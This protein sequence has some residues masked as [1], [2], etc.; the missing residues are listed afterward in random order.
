M[1]KAMTTRGIIVQA[2]LGA[3]RL[4]SKIGMMLTDKL[5]MLDYLLSN[6]Q[7]IE[8][9]IV[10]AMPASKEH[11]EFSDSLIA[12]PFV[13][14]FF[15]SESDVLDR[16]VACAHK[17]SFSSVIRVCGDNPFINIDLLRKLI[18]EWSEDYDYATYF[19]AQGVPAMKTHYGLFAEVVKTKALEKANSETQEKYFHEHVTPYIYEHKELFSIK[20][21]PMP[22][23]LFSGLPLRL[24]VDT[25]VD[26]ENLKK[27]VSCVSD[28]QKIS[29]IIKFCE[30]EGLMDNMSVE[31]NK[32]QK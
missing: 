32:N 17:Y 2:R 1:N 22:E 10:L 19:T 20:D 3:S 31:I 11:I 28:T 27:I 13:T 5:N 8:L 7:K 30:M 26:F 12:R 9:P 14:T 23:P 25:R 18:H 24:T 16:F 29:D 21:L 15:G 4:P 6:L